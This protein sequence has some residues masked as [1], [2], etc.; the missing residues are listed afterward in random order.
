[1][2]STSTGNTANTNA[3]EIGISSGNSF[4]LGEGTRFDFVNGLN[5][6]K[7]GSDWQFSY[8][9]TH[10]D[11]KA[12]R[13]EISKVVGTANITVT[14]IIADADNLFYSDNLDESKVV[15]SADDIKIYNAADQLLT[16]AQLAALGITIDDISDSH[17]VTINGLLQ[18][19]TYEVTSD[20]AFTAIQVDAAAGTDEFKLGFFSYGENSFGAP[21]DLSYQITGW[22]GDGDQA[23]GTID[24]SLYADGY[25][26]TGTDAGETH[27]GDAGNNVLLATGGND[28]LYGLG[29]DDIL[30][31]NKGDDMLYGGS[32]NDQLN[33]GAGHDHLYGDEGN[34]F[35]DGESGDD[36]LTGGSGADIFKAS[37]GHDH[38][39]DYD[40]LVDGDKID[41]AGLYNTGT[42]HL[43]VSD[44]GGKAKLS[45]MTDGAE[46]AS[47]TFDNI[48]YSE[49]TPGAE[50]DSLLGKVDVDG[51]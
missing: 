21:I 3:S 31:G 34:D 13:Q 2:M 29:G 39:T 44:D 50:L 22:D 19:Y 33:G 35:L 43:A 24:V 38:I 46:K 11:T 40:K 17:S 26:W 30:D 36:E 25:T 23:N 5:A 42:D 48:S 45:I 51:D 12:W 28:I 9:G 15:L 27:S 20:T 7:V 49:L 41:I 1:M 37:L 14:A 18:G 16:P 8:D 4:T 10:N 6:E 32:A 47:I